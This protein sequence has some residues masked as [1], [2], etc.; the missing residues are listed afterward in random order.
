MTDREGR[1]VALAIGSVA[2]RLVK[3]VGR[4]R[5]LGEVFT[6]KATVQEMLDLLPPAAWKPHPAYTFLEPACGDGNFLVA[7]LDRKL[8]EISRHHA[9]G[10]LAGGATATAARFHA[11]EA[12]ASIYGVDISVENVT[13]G[14]PDHEVGARDRLL[15]RLSDWDARFL[16]PD[17]AEHAQLLEAARWVVDHNVLIGN[18]LPVTAEGRPTGRDALPLIEYDWNPVRRTVTLRQTTMGAVIAAA[19]T[20]SAG[21]AGFF[22]S[23]PL[24]ELWS[25]E[26]LRLATASRVEAPAL[27]GPARNGVT[28][29]RR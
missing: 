12:L 20:D 19:E 27:V 17:A 15:A 5:D 10:T 28:A 11:L 29:H 2:E 7:M 4:V 14:T 22:A 13:G 16:P 26:A 18:M 21:T 9:A 25:G 3:S 23:V 8:Q 24:A 6:P 1:T